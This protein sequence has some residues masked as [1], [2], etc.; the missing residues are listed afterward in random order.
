[1]CVVRVTSAPHV[2][3]NSFYPLSPHFVVLDDHRGIFRRRIV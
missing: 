1:M 2:G 3:F